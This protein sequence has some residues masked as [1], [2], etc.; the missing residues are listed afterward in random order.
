MIA[1]KCFL[2]LVTNFFCWKAMLEVNEKGHI[3]WEK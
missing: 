2:K 1:T 3:D